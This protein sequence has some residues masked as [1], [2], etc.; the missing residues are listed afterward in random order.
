MAAQRRQ[1]PK[2]LA[3]FETHCFGDDRFRNWQMLPKYRANLLNLNP[4][5][6]LNFERTPPQV[7]RI[8]M[9]VCQLGFCCGENS[10]LILPHPVSIVGVSSV[11]KSA[12]SLLF[13]G[14]YPRVASG[15]VGLESLLKLPPGWFLETCSTGNA[16]F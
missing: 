12:A 3:G 10:T 6:E 11:V 8:R 4:Y 7:S 9:I 13:G 5:P 1:L 14:E 15:I 2:G 16:A